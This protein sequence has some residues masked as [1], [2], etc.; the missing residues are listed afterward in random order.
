M[1]KPLLLESRRP[2]KRFPMRLLRRSALLP[3]VVAL[4]PLAAVGCESTLGPGHAL[5]TFVLRAIGTMP[6]PV[7]VA[8]ETGGSLVH[9]ADTIRVFADG[10]A[11]MAHVT[12]YIQ[13]SQ[14]VDE[15]YRSRSAYRYELKGDSVTFFPSPP[16]IGL[17]SIE[18]PL[19]PS[20]S[21]GGGED[22]AG[23]SYVLPR[24]KFVEGG[25]RMEG[26]GQGERVYERVGGN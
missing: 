17:A 15:V 6:V 18:A 23:C 25:L 14:G 24:G 5:G 3:A 8:L 7:T 22:G 4:L 11:E 19:R 13:P 26:Y 16:C 2:P 12:R 9:I 10:T 20:P 1:V 21:V